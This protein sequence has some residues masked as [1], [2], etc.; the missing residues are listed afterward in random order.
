MVLPLALALA[1]GANPSR[2]EREG[3]LQYGEQDDGPDSQYG[4]LP[5]ERAP[6]DSLAWRFMEKEIGP[7]PRSNCTSKCNGRFK[8]VIVYNNTNMAGLSD[9]LAVFGYLQRLADSLCARL[10]VHRPH[11]ILS[12]DHNGGRELDHSYWW[13]RYFM[14]PDGLMDAQKVDANDVTIG[15]TVSS[16]A[17]DLDLA[18]LH[19]KRS[20]QFVWSIDSNFYDWWD[21]TVLPRLGEACEAEWSISRDFAPMTIPAAPS[22][23]CAKG[24]RPSCKNCPLAR[25]PEVC[26]DA[27]CGSCGGAGCRKREAAIG[28]AGT[29]RCCLDNI[30]DSNLTCTS[31]GQTA[32]LVPKDGS[33]PRGNAPQPSCDKNSCYFTSG[34]V[35]ETARKVRDSLG[36]MQC[37]HGKHACPPLYALHIRRGDTVAQCNT[38]VQAVTEYMSCPRF[39]P[40]KL[41][42]D[43]LVVFTDEADESY[44][45]GLVEELKKLPRWGGGVWHGDPL[46]AKMLHKDDAADNYLIYSIASV[47]MRDASDVFEMRKCNGAVSCDTLSYQDRSRLL[48]SDRIRDALA[49]QKRS[50]DLAHSA[51]TQG[52]STA[53]S[54]ETRN[55]Q[56]SHDDSASSPAPTMPS[57]ASTYCLKGFRASENPIC[58]AASCGQCGGEGCRKRPG[59][60]RPPRP[61]PTAPAHPRPHPTS[62]DLRW[63]RAVLSRGHNGLER[64]VHLADAR[65]VHSPAP[66]GGGERG[67]RI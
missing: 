47:M 8:S 18:F 51:T 30:I 66:E 12:V 50:S 22:S 35:K 41:G 9:R 64:H 45:H 15:P 52:A 46:I 53:K 29:G 43:R 11:K 65:G 3:A 21:D 34:V 36:D 60:T 19:R 54:T 2:P 24:L 17:K 48:I 20:K 49:A 62:P 25:A 1:L 58:C 42:N 55:E 27:A 10:A 39:E 13:D 38:S 57:P 32:C 14:I 31:A 63:I 16:I 59:A 44:L 56:S 23:W 28:A 4:E 40:E 61:R 33:S 6:V 37:A 67:G 5:P 7:V 26:C